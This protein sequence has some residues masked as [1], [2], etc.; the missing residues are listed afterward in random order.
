MCC[1]NL[2]CAQNLDQEISEIVTRKFLRNQKF[3]T[4]NIEKNYYFTL[5]VFILR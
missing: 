1:K 2:I 4:K 3:N 5:S